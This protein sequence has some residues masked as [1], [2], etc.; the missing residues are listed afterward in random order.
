MSSHPCHV[1]R[2]SI[3][4]SFF[5]IV[6]SSSGIIHAQE[7]PNKENAVEE[8]KVYITDLFQ[9]GLAHRKQITSG[10]MTITTHARTWGS[11]PGEVTREITIA[12]DENRRRIDRTN[13]Y[14][15]N[16]FYDEVACIGCY[17]KDNRLAF[18]Y[19]NSQRGKD[20][21]LQKSLMFYDTN[22]I[23]EKNNFWNSQFNFIPQYM[24]IFRDRSFPRKDTIEGAKGRLMAGFISPLELFDPDRPRPEPSHP[25]HVYEISV[26][27]TGIN[28][29]S[30]LVAELSILISG[31]T[32]RM[33][34]IKLNVTIAK[35]DYKGTLCKKITLESSSFNFETNMLETESLN[36]LWIAEEQ[37]YALRKHQYQSKGS[38]PYEE[39]LEVDVALDKG[40]GI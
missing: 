18:N 40:S 35:E 29:N 32:H 17:K 3:I 31:P 39:L 16:N 25:S 28:D 22:Q 24:G 30:P 7:I 1:I 36:T 10:Q 27:W 14:S 13:T 19:D 15:K 23:E 34:P 5:A 37:G 4:V 26:D 11:V 12:F 2:F 38:Y 9:K 6:F 21:R 8:L 20:E 33:V